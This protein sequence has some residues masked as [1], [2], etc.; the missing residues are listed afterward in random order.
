MLLWYKIGHIIFIITW[1]AGLFYLPRLFVYMVE[2]DKQDVHNVL[3]V[4]QRKLYYY[5]TVPSA[6]LATTF[7]VLLYIP[8]GA[9]YAHSG[10]MHLKLL[11]VAFLWAFHVS[12]GYYRRLLLNNDNWPSGRFFR[13][14]NEIPSVVLIA[15]VI[16][17]ILKPQ[18]S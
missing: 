8:M 10:W 15:V 6:V 2:S 11:L 12:C 18:F 9:Y 1:F 14:Y 5:I 4:M 13:M 17:V 16:L 3:R 7:G